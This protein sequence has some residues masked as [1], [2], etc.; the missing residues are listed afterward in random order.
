MKEAWDIL[1][2]DDCGS[3]LSNGSP[4]GGPEVALIVAA[5]T[6]SSSGEGLAGEAPKEA[7]HSAA[8]VPP[9]KGP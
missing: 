7:I 9:R 4:D 3:Y 5:L 8:P 2:E 1:K 6:A